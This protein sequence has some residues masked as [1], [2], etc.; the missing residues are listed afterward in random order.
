MACFFLLFV[1]YLWVCL[2]VGWCVCVCVFVFCLFISCL[3]F[4]N[5]SLIIQNLNTFFY[6]PIYI[7]S[8][9]SFSVRSWGDGSSDRS[10]MG[11]TGVTKAL[12]CVILSV[13]WCILKN[14]CCQSKRVA[15]VA[16]AGFLSR[17]LN[18]FLP[19]V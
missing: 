2:G 11:W 8:F 9:I 5:C 16:A 10:F 19:Y 18:V 1:C 7:R 13:G 12:V 15:H 3:R 14:P 17:Y 4:C 6:L